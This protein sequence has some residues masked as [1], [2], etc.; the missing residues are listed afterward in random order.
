[1]PFKE[2]S[3]KSEI[4]SPP[5][6]RI[7]GGYPVIY[8]QS[9]HGQTE[10]L[11]SNIGLM[12]SC[13]TFVELPG[14]SVSDKCTK[15]NLFKTKLF[16]LESLSKKRL[17]SVYPSIPSAFCRLYKILLWQSLYQHLP[18]VAKSPLHGLSLGLTL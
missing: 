15:T 2:I 9:P 4:S 8:G 16:S 13:T 5:H 3:F 14:F 11:L 12:T 6:F 7:Q 10:I 1:M 18:L 17:I